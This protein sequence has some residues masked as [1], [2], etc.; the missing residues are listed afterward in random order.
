[1]PLTLC[2]LLYAAP[3]AEELLVEYEDRVLP[4]LD[5]HGGRLVQRLRSA[6]S[7]VEPYEVHTIEFP[8]EAAFE[9]YMAD[10]ARHALNDLRARAIARTEVVRVQAVE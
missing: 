1:V 9:R 4:L 8:S 6:A 2:V 5:V 3:G 7:G 10:P